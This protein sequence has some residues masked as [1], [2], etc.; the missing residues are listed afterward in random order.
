MNVCSACSS[1]ARHQV[2]FDFRGLSKLLSESVKKRACHLSCHLSTHAS[3]H[4]SA[5][6]Y[7]LC[8]LRMRLPLA[9]LLCY[10]PSSG[11]EEALI[12]HP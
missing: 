9:L 8:N 1:A 5:H 6:D 10:S 12:P 7:S 11:V 3:L 2:K 4:G